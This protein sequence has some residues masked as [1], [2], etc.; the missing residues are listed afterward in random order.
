MTSAAEREENMRDA[1]ALLSPRAVRGKHVV[2]A[3][4]VMTTGATLKAFAQTLRPARPKSLCAIVLAVADP[5]GKDF[6][7]IGAPRKRGG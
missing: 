6:Q 3:D 4:D 5:K 7:S 2:V 1:F